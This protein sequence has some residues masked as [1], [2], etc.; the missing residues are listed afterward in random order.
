MAEHQEEI[1][2]VMSAAIGRPI[3]V[4]QSVAK[5]NLVKAENK[6][7]ADKRFDPFF[8]AAKKFDHHEVE[9]GLKKL[10]LPKD[11]KKE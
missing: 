5:Q 3:P 4:S 11:V 6:M 10:K 7:K 8:K 2:P 9:N 1:D